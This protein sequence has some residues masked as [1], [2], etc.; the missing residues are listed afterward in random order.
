MMKELAQNQTGLPLLNDNSTIP[1]VSINSTV[2]VANATLNGTDLL[3][4]NITANTTMNETTATSGAERRRAI[5]P[6]LGSLKI[7]R[8][9]YRW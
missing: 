7:P 3:G 5:R 1:M 6:R 2:S 9:P 8:L 4:L